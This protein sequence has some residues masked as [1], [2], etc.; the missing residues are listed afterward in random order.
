MSAGYGHREGRRQGHDRPDCEVVAGLPPPEPSPPTETTPAPTPKIAL[1][2]R[3][4]GYTN[5]GK[6]ICVTVGPDSRR[7]TAY[8]LSSEVDCGSAKRTFSFAQAGPALIQ[9]DLSFAHSYDGSLP[10][11]QTLKNISVS[12]EVSG[13]FDVAGNVEGAFWLRL[14]FDSAGSHSDCTSAPTAWQAK[15]GA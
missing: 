14:P 13:S 15:L 11:R 1:A 6:I 10:D 2:G 7:V 12:Y 3:Y 5:Q 8:S 9:A 4:C